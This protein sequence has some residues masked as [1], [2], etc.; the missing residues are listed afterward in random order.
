MEV[1]VAVVRVV[2]DDVQGSVGLSVDTHALIAGISLDDLPAPPKGAGRGSS[3]CRAEGR[4]R[5]AGD[6]EILAGVNE[7]EG[8]A[9]AAQSQ[10]L[11]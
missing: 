3:G 2:L 7:I 9:D 5:W 10:C 6:E 1:R 11:R 8:R 4:R